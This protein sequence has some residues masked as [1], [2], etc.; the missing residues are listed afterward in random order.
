MEEQKTRAKQICDD[1]RERKRVKRLCSRLPPNI[2]QKNEEVLA[3]E[4][5]EQVDLALL[6]IF[7]EE[8]TPIYY[9]M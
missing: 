5:E 6:R 8:Q 2:A 7:W 3:R 1:D 9:C 4:L